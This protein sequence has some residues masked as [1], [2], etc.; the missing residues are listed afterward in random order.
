MDGI[1]VNLLRWLVNLC[2]LNTPH[3]ERQFMSNRA[4]GIIAEF[5]VE[6]GLYTVGIFES[7]VT[8][9]SQQ[10]RAHNLV[11]ALSEKADHSQPESWAVIGGGIAGLTTAACALALFP[12][13][14]VTLFERQWE[15]CSMQLGSDSRWL[16]PRIYDWPSE[17]SR[18]PSASLP[19]LNWKEGRA[20]DVSRQI[21]GRFS[22]LAERHPGRLSIIL[23]ARHLKIRENGTQIEWLGHPANIE[24]G[25][26]KFEQPLGAQKKFDKT[27]L[28]TGYGLE[29]KASV[30]LANS[31]WENDEIG[32]PFFDGRRQAYLISGSGDGALI[33]LCR[34]CIS[35]FRQDTIV[36]EL[37]GKAIERREKALRGL[38]DEIILDRENT[39]SIFE[40]HFFEDYEYVIDALKKRLRNDTTVIMHLSGHPDRPNDSMADTLRAPTSFLNKFLFFAL[41]KAGAFVPAFGEIDAIAEEFGVDASSVLVRH[42][43]D[44][45]KNL[46]QL[47]GESSDLLAKVRNHGAGSTQKSERCWTPGS[48]PV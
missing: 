41:Y 38:R 14:K 47:F 9:Y 43:A 18:A 1:Q 27:F 5:C 6:K 36:Y 46:I 3:W 21:I 37:L 26:L 39:F 31:Y 22:D 8:V 25:F 10:V 2:K 23:G 19:I 44:R 45:E 29:Q 40:R 32:Q 42:G 12:S 13:V 15:L 28:A 7:G 30:S 17:G 24:G 35:R 20:S 4:D 11:S 34:L 16:H 48:I 33:D